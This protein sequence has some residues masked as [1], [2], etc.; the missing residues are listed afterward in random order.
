[1]RKAWASHFAS[2]PPRP[3]TGQGKTLTDLKRRKCSYFLFRFS[4]LEEGRKKSSG[5]LKGFVSE[6][7]LNLELWGTQSTQY[8]GRF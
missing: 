5:G 4:E 7:D 8:Q 3:A 2:N 1:M 6:G